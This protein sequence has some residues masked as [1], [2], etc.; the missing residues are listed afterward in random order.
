MAGGEDAD[1]DKPYEATQKRLDEA[2]KKGQ[3]PHS[4]DL[5]TAA[6]YGGLILAAMAFGADTLREFGGRLAALL[7]RADALSATWLAGPA[8]PANAAAFGAL[9]SPLAAWFGLPLLAGLVAIIAQNAFVVSSERLKPKLEKIS[10]IAGAKNKFGRNGLFE[11]AKSSVKLVIISVVLFVFLLRELPGMMTTMA[12]EPGQ[13]TAVML[14]LSAEF[15]ILVFVITLL[16]GAVDS[17][18]QRAEHARKNRMS[19]KELMDEQKDSEGDPWMK[20]K[21]RDKA[22]ELAMSQMISDVAK[23]DVVI[24]NPTH[25][26]VAL[27]WDRAVPGAAPTCVAKGVD[28]VA[29]RIREKAMECGVPI[30]HDPPTARALWGIVEVGQEIP[31]EHYRAVAVAIRFADR[32]RARAR[33]PGGDA[34]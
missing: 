9:L 1:D 23:A 8:A 19:R 15:L 21:R 29:Q 30:R 20:S 2:R 17:L 14:R 4:Q 18:W 27:R 16:F 26:A 3:V 28:S 31:P 10:P 5:T 6:A 11:F 24:V 13:A 33:R 25:Y 7:A 32:I 12:L 34:R 22:V